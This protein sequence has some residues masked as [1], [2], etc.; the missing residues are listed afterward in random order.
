MYGKGRQ[1]GHVTPLDSVT[2][3]I[4]SQMQE[5]KLEKAQK[6]KL[7][8]ILSLSLKS[9]FEEERQKKSNFDQFYKEKWQNIKK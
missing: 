7:F 8:F 6:N 5:K 3:S 2:K 4:W 9:I 1:G